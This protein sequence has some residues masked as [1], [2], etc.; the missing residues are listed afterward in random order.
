MILP[1]PCSGERC[2]PYLDHYEEAQDPDLPTQECGLSQLPGSASIKTPRNDPFYT[3]VLD[4]SQNKSTFFYMKESHVCDQFLP[5][6][7]WEKLPV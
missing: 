7:L 4:R 6:F 3:N 1:D 5:R 2:K